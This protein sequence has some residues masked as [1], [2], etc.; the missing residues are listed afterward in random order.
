MSLKHAKENTVYTCLQCMSQ[1]AYDCAK[2]LD[3]LLGDFTDVQARV[4]AIHDIEHA[5]DM[6][7]HQLTRCVSEAFI[8]PLDRE[9]LLLLG[10]DLDAV[11]DA[12]EDIA[13]G[14]DLLA[15]DH[16]EPPS[17]EFTEMIQRSCDTLCK[18][19]KELSSF[20]SS[21]L[22]NE[23]IIEVNHIEEE[24]DTL[25]HQSVR[26]LFRCPDPDPLH[27]MKW[28]ELYDRMEHVL[29]L[30]EDVADHLSTVSIK[31]Q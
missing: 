31:N 2:A 23:Y 1:H 30:C 16:P 25:Y 13:L 10:N 15:V 21:R 26:D 4:A 24:G 22:L 29:D 3:A 5:C 27:T 9:D 28:K 18:A 20:K 6:Q 8:T 14:F 7:L 11:T 12:I 19:M 17:L